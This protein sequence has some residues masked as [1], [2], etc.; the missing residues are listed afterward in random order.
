MWH[1]CSC[2]PLCALQKGSIVGCGSHQRPHNY[3]ERI[4]WSRTMR[5]V[6][7]RYMAL[8]M[9]VFTRVRVPSQ[10]RWPRNPSGVPR[11]NSCEW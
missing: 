3:N 5:F 2:C 10:S 4:N 9:G 6:Y 1:S 7:V 8:D 11:E